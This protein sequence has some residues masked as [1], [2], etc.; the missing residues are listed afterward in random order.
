MHILYS[1]GLLLAL[2]ITLP[3]WLVKMLTTGK[4]RAGLSER[5]GMVP[6]RIV[7]TPARGCI[8]IHAVS[9]GEVLA[10]GQL[11]EGL[12]V[13]YP[14]RRVLISTT[15]ATG[16]KLA[17]ERYGEDNAFFFSLDF[18]FAIRPYLRTLEPALI[19]LAETEFWPNFLRL[20]KST[21]ARLVVV[22]GRISDRSY[23]RYLRMRG[24]WRKLLAN[25]DRFLAQTETDAQRLTE[26]GAPG[27][28][29]Q[30]AGNLKFDVQAPAA[31]PV[32]ETLRSGF[33]RA[34][35]SDVI[36]CGSTVEGEE[37]FV[38]EAF[39]SVLK[40]RPRATLILAPRHPE[41][42]DPVATL[43]MSSSLSFIRRSRMTGSE[44]FAGSVLLLDTIGELAATYALATVAFVGG[45]LVPRGG[46]NILEPAQFGVATMVGPHTEN[47]RDIIQIFRRSNAVRVFAPENFAAELTQLLEDPQSRQ[48]LGA[49]AAE[50]FRLQS[51]ATARTVEAIA[52]LL[53]RE[54]SAA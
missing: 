1:A 37:P 39:R 13:R 5:L 8:W 29:V 23:P 27:S 53:A 15:T 46:H 26:I 4:Y 16:Q 32:V 2:L 33:A 12:R 54:E 11:V 45:S 21:G 24:L 10:I 17:R 30:V 7:R 28:R 42:F 3:Y 51:G 36:V 35:V 44:S 25:V 20:A 18:A 52:A 49:R 50:V 9:V 48:Q 47:F 43:L 41:R 31:Q 14:Q 34:G 6:P 40:H 22:N 19:I 38:L